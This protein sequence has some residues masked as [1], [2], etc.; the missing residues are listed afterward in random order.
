MNK[1]EDQIEIL[2]AAENNLKHIDVTIPKN[3]LVVF[4][5]VSGS[6]KSSLAFDTVAVE[7]NREWQQSYPLFLRNKMPHYDRPKVD[8]IRNLTPAI[9]VDQHAIG[10]NAR[11]TVGTAVDVAPLM[12][13]L[14]SRVG[15]PSAG[16]SM[17]YSFNHPAG[18]C[19]DCT[20]IGEQLELIEES[21]FDQ[22]KTL[23]EGAILFSQFSAGWQTHLYQNNPLLDPNKKLRDFS[24]EE[25]NT[26]KYGSREP[27]KVGIKSNN[28]GR[29]D[30]V[31]YEGVFP[32]FERVYMKR[33]I[34]KLK[35]SLQEEIMSHVRHGFCKTC[36][37]SGLNPKALASR[38]N[39]KNIVECMDMTAA[40]LLPFL[41]T[42]DEPMG[43]SL[44]K[45]IS[46]YLERMIDV[47]IGYLSLSRKTETLSGGEAQRLKMVRNLGGYL[48]NI[49]YIFDEP[50]AGL[51]P[52]DA[53]RIG[54]LLCNLRDKHNNVLVVEHSR[55]MISLADRIIEM[56]PDAG[57]G[58]G[59]VVFEGDLSELQAANTLTAEAMRKKIRANTDPLP[60]TDCFEIRDAHAHNLKHI[61]VKIPKGV[62]TA[63]CGVA[64][65]GKSSLA[66][67]E[68]DAQYPDA[69]VID[70]KPIG[71]SIRSTPAT[72]TGVIDEI[73]KIFAKE[74]GI[75]PGWFSFNSEGGC[76]V[77]KGTGQITYD[78]AFAEPVVV[79]CEECGGHRYNPTALSSKYKGMNIEEVMSLTI[80]QAQD[81]FENV[82]IRK[83]LQSMI[84]VGLGYMTLGQPTSTLSGG[85]IQRAK[86]ASELHR[87]GQLYILDEPSTGLHNRDIEKLLALLRKLVKNRNTVVIV[88]H[89][90]ELIAQADWVIDMGPDGGSGGG[91]VIYE[92]TPEG[93][94]RCE[95]S[96]TAKYLKA[97]I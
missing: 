16:G 54:K 21:M 32:R 2:S 64:G 4:A 36:G 87:E 17:A 26:L 77:C 10:A 24:D 96:K 33:D 68:L 69:I 92:G 65:S 29:V 30:M 56:G 12:R 13:L 73:R 31:D 11:S 89:R 72:Y 18:M 52:A 67:Y 88:E 81:F 37:G 41:R 20:G 7:S 86:L 95:Q 50:T 78:M 70:Q 80:E 35:K 3:K 23:A 44:A 49:T 97:M 90:L 22:G 51:H 14:F 25:W 93:L 57:T 71:T 40:D 75:K 27:I 53:E 59:T 47:G 61:N 8:E 5:G 74:H 58:G 76:P 66:R 38:I 82:K 60:W 79:P 9:V 42:I 15:N 28:T 91:E 83:L 39:G 43:F 84:D 1:S 46:E 48:N 63:I 6:G 62:L 45:Q 94:L 34:T 55:Q 85:E 19:P